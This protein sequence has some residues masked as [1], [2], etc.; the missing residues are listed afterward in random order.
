MSEHRL[1]PPRLGDIGRTPDPRTVDLVW[2]VA[3]AG[4][5]DEAVRALILP[6]A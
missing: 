5:W 6:S 4:G 2:I 3:H 1:L